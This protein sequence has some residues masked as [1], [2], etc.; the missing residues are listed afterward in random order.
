MAWNDFSKEELRIILTTTHDLCAM[1][2]V[3]PKCN[4]YRLVRGDQFF[5][6]FAHISGS[7]PGGDRH[8]DENM[9]EEERESIDNIITATTTTK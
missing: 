1:H 3:E 8:H 7:K 6:E 9:T 4:G 5:G 2:D